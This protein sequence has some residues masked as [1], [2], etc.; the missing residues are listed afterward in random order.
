[1]AGIE[2][3]KAKAWLKS[4]E[5]IIGERQSEIIK[6]ALFEYGDKLFP[7]KNWKKILLNLIQTNNSLELWGQSF[8]FA[9]MNDARA[10]IDEIYIDDVYGLRSIDKLEYIIDAG[11]SNGFFAFSVK[12]YFP[13]AIIDCI[14]PNE[15]NIT[16]INE[17]L[18]SHITSGD[19]RI[20]AK[21]MHSH[22]K[23]TS[24]NIPNDVNLWGGLGAN[25]PDRERTKTRDLKIMQVDT[26]T[27]SNFLNRKVSLLKCDIEGMEFEVILEAGKLIK[28]CEKLLIEIH[29][30]VNN[31]TAKYTK[32]I[33]FLHHND[34]R[35]FCYEGASSPAS[36]FSGQPSPS[37]M[38]C[39]I[40]NT[41]SRP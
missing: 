24:I 22:E 5:G 6:N 30:D 10:L 3:I 1:V 2:V 7:H 40:N 26:I 36:F 34:F 4:L 17:N 32:L 8:K 25:I 38:L 37:F 13:D 28:N 27:L 31:F 33:S 35:V 9:T 19:V 15:N 39:A 23:G 41:C 29:S 20:T 18:A 11:A 14:E 16:L 12:K 21:A